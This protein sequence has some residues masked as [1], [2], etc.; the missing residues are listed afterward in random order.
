MANDSE[1]K[2]IATIDDKNFLTKITKLK[3]KLL[4]FAKDAESLK[5]FSSIAVGLNSALGFTTFRNQQ[6]V[7]VEV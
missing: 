6:V 3:Q 4:S 7:K 1:I 5:K 2:M